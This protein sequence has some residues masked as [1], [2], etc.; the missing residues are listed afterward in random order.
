MSRYSF[1]TLLV[2]ANVKIYVFLIFRFFWDFGWRTGHKVRAVIK[3]WVLNIFFYT[4][5]H[6]EGKHEKVQLFF[7]NTPVYSK[8]ITLMKMVQL[9]VVWRLWD[10]LTFLMTYTTI[11]MKKNLCTFQRYYNHFLELILIKSTNAKTIMHRKK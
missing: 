3:K 2:I 10:R 7:E 8:T 1:C 11:C 6:L 9:F 4:R 5:A